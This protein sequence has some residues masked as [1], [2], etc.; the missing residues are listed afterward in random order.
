MKLITLL[1]FVFVTLAVAIQAKPIEDKLTAQEIISK[2]LAA[3]GGKENLAKVKTLVATGKVKRE[4]LPETAMLMVS[5]APDRLS[6]AYGFQEVT[7]RLI[8]DKGKGSIRPTIT[9]EYSVM[10]GKFREMLASGFFYNGATI[11]NTLL[12]EPTG[13][14]KIEAKGMKKINGRQNYVVEYKRDK[15]SSAYKLFFDAETFMWVR[16]E[17]GRV[18]IPI[19][20]RPGAGVEANSESQPTVDFYIETSDFKEVDGL[21]L[22][23]KITH[24]ATFPILRQQKEGTLTITINDYKQNVPIDP[25]MFP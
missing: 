22:P 10:E 16:T 25:K 24:T 9:G 23:H 14:A 7:W 3:I 4:S 2:H 6:I 19:Q 11:F 5:E 1:L 13:E 15:K 8:Y 18:T 21:K 20:A 12:T 17:F